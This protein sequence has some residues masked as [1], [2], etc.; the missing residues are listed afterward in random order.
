[1]ARAGMAAEGV[2]AIRIA[3]EKV[4][5]IHKDLDL[6]SFQSMYDVTGADVDVA[7]FL[8]GEPESMI[9]YTMVDTPRSG[10][11]ITLVVPCGYSN[12]T[13]HREVMEYGTQALALALVLDSLGFQSE[14]W[15]DKVSH[16]MKSRGYRS[17]VRTRVKASGEELD[18]GMLMY[19]F[20]S[21]T[22]L[23]V[24]QFAT[25]R[26]LPEAM[27]R[28]FWRQSWITGV[29]DAEGY[30][31]ESLILK[32]IGWSYRKGL[33]EESLRELGIIQ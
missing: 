31:P 12:G 20:S 18:P 13:K 8:S 5:L 33:V 6:P 15:I 10:R 25:L 21:P 11:V 26:R 19:C 7:R 14:I 28:V 29:P 24:V 22:F 3:D 16:P 9:N 1:M 32:S 2:R 4:K 30:P 23:R 17:S 27:R